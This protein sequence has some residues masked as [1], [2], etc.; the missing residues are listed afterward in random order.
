MTFTLPQNYFKKIV[1]PIWKYTL[2]KI[3]SKEITGGMW[4]EPNC[5]VY[6]NTE[7]KINEVCYNGYRE[8]IS[9]YIQEKFD[10]KKCDKQYQ[11]SA[12]TCLKV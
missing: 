2:T 9:I 10:V 5:I 11:L 6:D 12:L 4:S 8:Y 1:E 7:E 3:Q